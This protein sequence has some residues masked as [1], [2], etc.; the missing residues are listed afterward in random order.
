MTFLK[1]LLL[2]IILIPKSVFSQE[3]KLAWPRE[4]ESKNRIVTIYQ[5]QLES[6]K[7][8][9][10][11]GRM[12]ISIKPKDG[13]IIFCAAWFKAKM[14]TDLDERT[15]ILQSVEIPRIHF[16]EYDD[17]ETINKFTKLLITEIESWDI[18]MSLDRLI[19]SLENI[20][21][22]KKISVKLNNEP[23]DIYFRTAPTTLI[24]IDGEPIM[25]DI[26]NSNMEYVIN[27][28]FFMVKEKGKSEVY[29]NGGKFWYTSNSILTGWKETTK[30]PS[31]IKKLAEQNKKEVEEDSVSASITEAPDLIVVTEP[32]EIITTDGK[33]DYQSIEG[34]SLLYVK[35]SESDIIMDINSQDHYV[36]LAGRWFHSKTLENGDWKFCEP[37]Q[38]PKDFEKIPDNSEMATV[39]ASIPN[40]PEAQDALLEQSIPQTATVDRKSAKVEVNYD[41][42][43]EFKKVEGTEVYYAVNSDK[44]ILRIKNKYYCVDD[45]IWFIADNATGPWSVSDVRP[46][47]VDQL[48]PEAEVYNVKYVYIYDSTP[49]VVYVGYYPGYT[50]SYA[51]NGVVVYGTGYHY[52]PWYRVHYY[53]RAVTWG[54]GVHWN[55]YTGWGFHVGFSY[56]WIGWGFHPYYRHYWG[57]RGYH[58]GYRH[59]YH[60]GYHHGARAGFR[61]GYRAGQRRPRTNNVYRN[62]KS[63]VRQTRTQNKASVTRNNRARVSGKPN[64]IYTDNRGN[65][66]Q[67]NKDGSWTK[68]S[69]RAATSKT[70]PST[71][72]SLA[73]QNNRNSRIRSS[74][75]QQLNRSYQSRSRGNSSYNRSRST[76]TRSSGMRMGGGRRR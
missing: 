27:T 54:Y 36:L 67:R 21:D 24:S 51:Y 3:E 37:N 34:T 15:V 58:H 31:D 13:D 20:E 40:T 62:H 50:Y 74:N 53:P 60:R 52:A 41:G 70:R 49:D 32:S 59:G 71:S 63:G 16:P 11:Q 57:P 46:D 45:A 5:P 19:A 2:A 12:A 30:I 10:L 39:R 56:G 8:D 75:Q 14:T 17:K 7:S 61:A 29:V 33:P 1:Y 69:N 73:K 68:K 22:L 26:D 43:P 42:N 6:F 28:P 4:I 38:L 35:N 47:E 72:N 23:P 55:P 66:H 65:I 64:N 44:T 18:K 25:K 48:P 9:T 76:R